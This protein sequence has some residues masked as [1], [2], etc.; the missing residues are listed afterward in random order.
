MHKDI[1]NEQEE[2][3]AIVDRG[4]YQIEVI[5]QEFDTNIEDLYKALAKILVDEALGR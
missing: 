1:L 2:V 5:K 3:L 4:E